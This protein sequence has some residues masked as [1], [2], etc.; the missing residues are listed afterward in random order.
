MVGAMKI[1]IFVVLF[2]I[3]SL[4]L[5]ATHSLGGYISYEHVSGL[6]YEVTVT[7]WQD[8]NSPAIE[9]R[10]IEIIWGDNSGLDSIDRSSTEL[11]N[12]DAFPLVKNIYKKQHTFPSAAFTYTITVEDPNRRANIVNIT[13]SVN[14]ALFLQTSLFIDPFN[15]IQNNA[16][17]V[18]AELYANC[19]VGRAF[20]YNLAAFD[21]DGDFLTY[22]LVPTKG[23]SGVTAQGYQFPDGSSI[24]LVNGELNWTPRST[25]A[26][27]FSIEITECRGNRNIAKTTVDL[28]IGCNSSTTS[29]SFSN[30]NR[31]DTNHRGE[32]HYTIFPGDSVKFNV[33]YQSNDPFTL[34][35]LNGDN[36][37][38]YDSLGNFRF[39]STPLD[40]R[41][42]PLLFVIEA[43]STEMKEHLS[44]LISVFDSTQLNCDT[45]CGYQLISVPEIN[46]GTLKSKVSPNPFSK[47]TLIQIQQSK[48]THF[49]FRLF[50]SMGKLMEERLLVGNEVNLKRNGLTSGGYFYTL[51]STD[52]KYGSGKLIVQ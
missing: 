47:S 6:T 1:F 30:V 46:D 50:N 34:K 48:A 4:Q 41:C 35:L 38:T 3:F 20:N 42:V 7:I 45:I 9:R 5:I 32:I 16:A 19:Q 36:R 13:N 39:T 12:S 21:Q 14:Q 22:E 27:Q 15:L 31:L 18:N 17:T 52:G 51:S 29:S 44:I 25:G 2:F 40:N 23:T 26:F 10:E 8:G 28:L 11:V 43:S 37:A 24:K 33:G 49:T